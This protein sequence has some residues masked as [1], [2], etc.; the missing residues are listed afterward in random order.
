MIDE[1]A[2]KK[3]SQKETIDAKSGAL[4]PPTAVSE[5]RAGPVK[6]FLHIGTEKTGTTLLQEWLH[7]NRGALSRAGIYLPRGL[8]SP[9][10]RAF[11][12]FFEAGLDDWSVTNGIGSEEDKRLHFADFPDRLRAEVSQAGLTHRSFVIS[13]EHLQS[14]LRTKD[15]IL[16]VRAL[17]KECFDEVVVICYFRDQFEM[18]VSLYSTAM[19]GEFTTDIESFLDIARPEEYYFNFLALADNW[20]DVF[21]VENCNFRIFD[22][23]HFVDG[24]LRSDFLSIVASDIC[25]PELDSKRASS[26]SSLHLLQAAAY[27]VVNERIPYWK[28]GMP[29]VNPKN[30]AAK[31][32]IDVISS[33]K[34]GKISSRRAEEI[35]G[36]FKEVNTAFF[37]KYFASTSSFPASQT[38][39]DGVI[40]SD[41]AAR[42]VEDAVR[43]GIDLG[44]DMA[45]ELS[46][47]EVT[48]LMHIAICIHEGRVPGQDAAIGLMKLVSRARPNDR[49]IGR[50]V[51]QWTSMQMPEAGN[52][53]VTQRLD[54]MLRLSMR[55]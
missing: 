1:L 44:R 16:R 35:R 4:Y 10:H 9:S 2:S 8:G 19:R 29:G 26:N 36:R 38:Q 54:R 51:E 21:G 30:G 40:A 25:L 34:V 14:R 33:L 20:S 55:Q 39:F 17:L 12:A 15:Q 5:G 6:C 45:I 49:H 27:K 18:A 28:S 11:S 50:K 46:D 52:T 3:D 32:M 42:A 37:E 22:P 53:T 24:D 43:L 7:D 13:S 48:S 47:D 23:E 41:E 31:D